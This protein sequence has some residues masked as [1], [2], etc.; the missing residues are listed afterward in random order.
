MAFLHR[1][2]AMLAFD[3]RLLCMAFLLSI[4]SVRIGK[5]RKTKFYTILPAVINCVI[6]LPSLFTNWFA[7]HDIEGHL[8]RGIFFYEPHILFILYFNFLM[9]MAYTCWHAYNRK[10]EAGILIM[11]GAVVFVSVA[12]ELLFALKGILIGAIS[13]SILGYYLYVH[14]E[15]FRFDNLTQIPNRDAFKV[16]TERTYSK[17][18]I[19]HVLSIDL[20]NL[21][22]IN[23]TMGHNE[24]DK[25]LVTVAK[26]LEESKL[27]N[28]KVYRIGGDEFAAICIK[29]TTEEVELM[30]HTMYATVKESGYSVAIG[31]SEWAPDKT[32][33]EV[34]KDA[35]DNMYRQKRKI[36]G[37]DLEPVHIE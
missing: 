23:D 18:D 16:D 25:A 20:N 32:F 15:H 28:C 11:L 36:K 26:A 31:Y 14:V 10:T 33:K 4:V 17:L 19:T 35:D 12:V 22:V 8:Q 5:T 37:L 30:I 21:K 6:M 7:Y 27:P 1:A 34:Y 29:K 3:S 9:Y 2:V 13:L 24:G